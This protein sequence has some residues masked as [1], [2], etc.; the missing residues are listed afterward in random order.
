VPA[1]GNTALRIP[2]DENVVDV[3]KSLGNYE[4]FLLALQVGCNHCSPN[5]HDAAQ[6]WK[7]R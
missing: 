1:S 5:V 4:T 6:F 3:L 2:A 7:P